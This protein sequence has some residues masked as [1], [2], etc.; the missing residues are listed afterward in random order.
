[1]KILEIS[2]RI[3][4]SPEKLDESIALYERLLGEKARLRFKYDEVNLELA[5]V[6]P[7]LLIAGTDEAL[8][9]FRATTATFLV[10]S[11]AAYHEVLVQSGAQVL[12]GPRRVPT[13]M[14]MTVLHPD[15][16]RI[17]YVQLNKEQVSHVNFADA[18][19]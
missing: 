15:G 9:P 16:T 17:E 4:L 12:D 2:P 7:L 1:M 5:Q 10:D 6:G 3:Y 8:R 19:H 11:L 13:G 14:N 18:S